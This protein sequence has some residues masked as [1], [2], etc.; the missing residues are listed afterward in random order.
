MSQMLALF[1]IVG[2]LYI[3][4]AIAVRTKAWIPSVFVCAVL[5]LLGY[6][7]IFPKDIVSIAGIPQVVAVTLMYLLIT[8]MGTLLSLKELLRQWKTILISLAGILGIIFL[9]FIIGVALFDLN[10]VLVAVPPLVGGIVSSLIMSKGAAEAGLV[11]LSVFAI[12]IYVMQGF[13]GYPL[14]AIMLKKEGRRVLEKYRNGQWQETLSV[15]GAKEV[16]VKTVVSEDEMP[17][18]FKK[19][20]NHYNTS[21]FKFLR[22]AAVGYLAYLASSFAAPYVSISP[23]VLCL[24][25]GV[26]AS[27]LGFLERQPLQKANGF[28]FAI[29]ALMLFIFDTLNHATPDM[30]LRLVYPMV[31][32][33]CAAVI[34]MYLA[35]WVVGKILGVTKEM[36]FAVALTALYGFPADYIITN[37]AINAL[38]KDEKER[39]VL[40]SHMLGPMLVGG[41][42]SVTMVSVVLAG[43]MVAYIVPIAG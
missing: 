15:D 32:L 19:I 39:Q 5:F 34:G 40:T 7:T 29:M 9:T 22:L 38:T 23:F 35:S 43:I 33:I 18:M 16:E 12:L 14:T 36:A 27:S 28:G 6:W 4:D 25:F 17:R 37:E 20:P 8:N 26:I 31:V 21:Y 1:L 13:A 42:I 41:F 11:D 10:T 30:L 2:I 24:L 3:G